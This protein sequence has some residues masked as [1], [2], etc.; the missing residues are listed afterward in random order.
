MSKSFRLDTTYVNLG[1]DDSAT[2]IKIGPR[3]WATIEK[4]TDL[5]R[6]R[7]LGTTRQ[8]ADWPIWERHPAGDEILILLSGEIDLVLESRAGERRTRLTAGRT[9]VVPRGTWHRAVVREPGD[10]MF[11]TPGAGTEHRPVSL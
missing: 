9:F 7:L 4:R 8:K 3:F 6:G 5:K 2:A 11:I 1:P 10:L